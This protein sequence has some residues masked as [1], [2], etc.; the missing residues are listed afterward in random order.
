[1]MILLAAMALQLSD[2]AASVTTPVVVAPAATT[3]AAKPR[4]LEKACKRAPSTGSMIASRKT[5]ARRNPALP[6]RRESPSVA[7]EASEES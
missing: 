5:C 6:A 7:T 3:T 4:K 1:M 2:P